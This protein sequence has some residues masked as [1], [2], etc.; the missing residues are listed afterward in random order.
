MSYVS[1][2]EIEIIRWYTKS[3]DNSTVILTNEKLCWKLG[4][5]QSFE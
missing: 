4:L 2:S 5:N 1:I 3:Y